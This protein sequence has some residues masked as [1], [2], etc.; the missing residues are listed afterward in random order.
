MIVEPEREIEMKKSK[1]LIKKKFEA[2]FV[3]KSQLHTFFFFEKCEIFGLRE[4]KFQLFGFPMSTRNGFFSKIRE[5]VAVNTEV[6]WLQN[7]QRN[8]EFRVI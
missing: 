3:P 8:R 6:K 2:A 1:K 7:W 5:S 4:R